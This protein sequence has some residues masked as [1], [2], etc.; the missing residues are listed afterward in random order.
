MFMK[1]QFTEIYGCIRRTDG[2]FTATRRHATLQCMRRLAS[3]APIMVLLAWGVAA[4]AA[5]LTV[6]GITFSDASGGFV[7]ESASGTGRLDDPFVVVE[8]ITGNGE[9]ALTVTGLT[10]AF[11][12]RI[13]TAHLA[14]FALVKVVRND[15]AQAWTD[16]PVELERHRGE[17]ST[18]DDG[19]SFAQGP[20]G[21][22]SIGSDGFGSTRII[23]EP[24]DG[25]VFQGG[26]IPPGGTVTLHLVITDNMPGGPIFLVQ[27]RLTPTAALA[28]RGPIHLTLAPDPSGLTPG[29]RRP[30]S[31]YPAGP[32]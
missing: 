28:P 2:G 11:G 24:H 20:S 15:T 29:R 8:R 5:E 7:L 26:S 13:A 32:A 10:P 25:L 27:R 19:L 3:C 9:A 31:L 30:S 12:N 21:A 6:A 16:F 1:K 23:D 17:G 4:H 18:Y 14:G 22:R